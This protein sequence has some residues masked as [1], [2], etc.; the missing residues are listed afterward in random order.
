PGGLIAD[1]MGAVFIP[2]VT[3]RKLLVVLHDYEK[4]KEYYKPAVVDSRVL[5]C[6]EEDQKYSVVLQHRVLFVTAAIVAPYR[7]RDFPADGRRGYKIT[8]T[9]QV[10]EI[11][12]YG[13]DR[14]RI[15]PPDQGSG[16]I[17][18]L[19]IIVRYEERNGGVY[20]E[21]EALALSRDMPVSLRWLLI[22]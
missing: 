1:L 14:E 8:D 21:L 10:Q 2:N 11:E 7:A 9:T 22:P 16:Y 17:W 19:H 15:L 3:L 12:N 13:Q 6:S 18:R 20:L 5:D 4:Y